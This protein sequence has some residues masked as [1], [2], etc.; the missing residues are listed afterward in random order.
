[1]LENSSTEKVTTRCLYC[2]TSLVLY[3]Q[4][5]SMVQ[6]S[7]G[8]KIS[9]FSLIVFQ[10]GERLHHKCSIENPFTSIAYENILVAFFVLPVG[11]FLAI[12]IL[13]AESV[14]KSCFK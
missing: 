11:M 7:T 1:M 14:K 8:D 10:L 5:L 4:K 13:V 9:W 2:I 6:P 3:K 12:A